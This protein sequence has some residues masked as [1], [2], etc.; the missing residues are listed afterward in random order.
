MKRQV[1]FL[2]TG[3]SARSQ[4]AEALVNRFRGEQWRAVS[5]GTRPIGS[6][7]PLAIAAMQEIGVDLAGARSKSTEEF[8][9]AAFDVVIT[10]CDSAAEECPLWLGQGKRAHIGF[11]D[12]ARGTLD[13]FRA[14]REDIRRRVIEFLDSFE[15]DVKGGKR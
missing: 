2:C 12:P 8:R 11:S 7:H 6:V 1:L 4:I 3:N 14:V 5:A 10:V 15:P 13:D 9:A